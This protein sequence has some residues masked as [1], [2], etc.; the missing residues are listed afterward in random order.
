MTQPI[1]FLESV[2]HTGRLCFAEATRAANRAINGFYNERLAAADINIAQFSLLVRL[3]YRPDI[4]LN[5]LAHELQTD[6]TTLSRNLRVL[7]R[8]GHLHIG[9]GEDRRKRVAGLTEKGRASLEQ[10]LPLWQ[11]A[12]AEL[13]EKLGDHDWDNLFAGLHGLARLPARH[14]QARKKR[15]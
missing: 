9:A 8:S 1:A 15:G 6:R 12:Q 13:R 2:R 7:Q 10:A 4:P 11:R 5:Q 3:Y 14:A